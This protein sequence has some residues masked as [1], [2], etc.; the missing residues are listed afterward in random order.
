VALDLEDRVLDL[1]DKRTI[2]RSIESKTGVGMNE[3]KRMAYLEALGVDCYV[4]RGQLPGAAPTRRLAIISGSAGAASM[5][6]GS[7]LAGSVPRAPSGTVPASINDLQS[8]LDAITSRD[9]SAN[10]PTPT[11]T[12]TREGQPVGASLPR[13]SLAAIVVG[14]WLWLEELGGMPLATEQVRLMQSMAQA[15]CLAQ[16]QEAAVVAAATRP[17]VAQFDWPIHT[18]RQLDLGEEA[19][20]AGVAGFLGRRLEQCGCQ[21]LVVLGEPARLWVLEKELN[22][23]VMHT[24]STVE[25]LAT[26]ALKQAVWQ[27]L[28]PL[29]TR[30]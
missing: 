11:P 20:R 23:P 19:A 12:P 18:N 5:I 28:Q 25:M 15:L 2:K 4:S 9:K 21:G 30:T 29:I 8:S 10:T 1:I 16:G 7:P 14:N 6:S 27:D 13:F 22:L 3:L 24:S 17:D 26:P